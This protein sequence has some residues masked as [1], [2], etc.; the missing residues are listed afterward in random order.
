MS[1]LSP[2][3]FKYVPAR[4]QE[5]PELQSSCSL[6]VLLPRSHHSAVFISQTHYPSG[7]TWANI[8]GVQNYSELT[9]YKL[10]Y[11]KRAFNLRTAK[12]CCWGVSVTSLCHLYQYYGVRF[13]DKNNNGHS[14][15]TVIF[16]FWKYEQVPPKFTP[17]DYDSKW[18]KEVQHNLLELDFTFSPNG[19]ICWNFL[20][21]NKNEKNKQWNLTNQ[22]K[23]LCT[24]I[25]SSKEKMII[26]YI[27]VL[28]KVR[29]W[30]F[31]TN[32]NLSN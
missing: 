22:D 2:L 4:I 25:W 18:G 7:R 20:N 31:I 13:T 21:S 12:K 29:T 23:V 1:S 15:A 3:H 11:R 10:F 9:H 6:I 14:S 8:L 19:E 27:S 5:L 26:G 24:N 17:L 30:Q 16:F 28:C 32:C